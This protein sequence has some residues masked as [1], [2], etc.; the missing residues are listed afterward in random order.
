MGK[1]L[2]LYPPSEQDVKP[3]TLPEATRTNDQVHVVK[4]LTQP[5]VQG[6]G[7]SDVRIS[8]VQIGG[9]ERSQKGPWGKG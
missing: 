7:N 1:K 2:Y 8:A 3:L 9:G 4:L 5:E 6:S